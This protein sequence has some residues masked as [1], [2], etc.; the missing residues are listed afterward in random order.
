MS[1]QKYS[2]D[3]SV[4]GRDCTSMPSCVVRQ[5]I[6]SVSGFE[7]YPV[8]LAFLCVWLVQTLVETDGMITSSLSR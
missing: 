5:C 7:S 4:N 1:I 6:C 3:L 2:L 8:D